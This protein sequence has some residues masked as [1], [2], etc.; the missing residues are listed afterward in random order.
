MR[1]ASGWLPLMTAALLT[2]LVGHGQDKPESGPPARLARPEAYYAADETL[3]EKVR[4]SDE[5]AAKLVEIVGRK[6]KPF[7]R[8]LL[9][10]P[11]GYFVIGGKPY[12]FYGFIAS[13]PAKGN[14]WDDPVLHKFWEELN[15]VKDELGP[16]KDFKP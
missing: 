4:L 10:L 12:A 2:S 15:R 8:K 11:R 1:L 7:E 9:A 5:M 14:S 6:P 3:K 16:L 13:D